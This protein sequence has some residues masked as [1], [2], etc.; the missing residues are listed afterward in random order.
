MFAFMD[1]CTNWILLH[2]LGQSYLLIPISLICLGEV[3]L[4]M[5]LALL[6]LVELVKSLPRK[7]AMELILKLTKVLDTHSTMDG[8]IIVM[9]TTLCQVILYTFHILLK[10][11]TLNFH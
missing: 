8:T 9:N 3:Q 4:Y 5:G 10:F 1:H 6:C 7:V 11:K 2:S